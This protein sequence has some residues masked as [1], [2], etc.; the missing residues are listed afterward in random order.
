VRSARHTGAATG[1]ARDGTAVIVARG[2]RMCCDNR[3]VVRGIDL[4]VRRGEIFALVGPAGAGKTS[5]VELLSGCRRRTAGDVFVFGVDPES[6]APGW[7][8][9]VAVAVPLIGNPELVLLDEPTAGLDRVARRLVW[10]ALAD[11]R[12]RGATVLLATASMEEAAAVADRIAV[13]AAGKIVATGTARTL[14]ARTGSEITFVL[15]SAARVA[16]LPEPAR[17]GAQ[18]DG[19]RRVTVRSTV[20]MVVLGALAPW[21]EEHGWP[22]RDIEVRRPNLEDFYREVTAGR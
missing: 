5:A 12:A 1:V 22:L 15:P 18:V 19:A 6:A 9:R 20:P 7:R 2:L 3:E 17:V 10:N 14:A 4:D 13:L 16:D 11:A 21:A 8:T